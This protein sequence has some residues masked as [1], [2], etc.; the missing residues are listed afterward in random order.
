MMA[1][2]ELHVRKPLVPPGVGSGLPTYVAERQRQENST[3]AR[4][5]APAMK[6]ALP[7]EA[8]TALPGPA[9]Q[10]ERD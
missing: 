7:T 9:E 10:A 3:Y 4:P 2:E 5:P 6:V 1:T 8:P